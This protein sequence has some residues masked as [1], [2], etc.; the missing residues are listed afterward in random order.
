M[1]RAGVV[2]SWEGVNRTAP[3]LKG[4]EEKSP[5]ASVLKKQH[6]YPRANGTA[7]VNRGVASQ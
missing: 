1:Q 2:C 3:A 6:A 7:R 5:L 4:A